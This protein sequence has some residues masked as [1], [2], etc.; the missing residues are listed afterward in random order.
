MKT[1]LPQFTRYLLFGA[2]A[3]I[4]NVGLTALLHEVIHLSEETAFAISL[5]V[6]F[7]INFILARYMIFQD[8]AQ[9]GNIVKQI[10][11]YIFSALTFRTSEYLAFLLIHTLLGIRYI[12]SL[13]VILGISFVAKFF[14]YRAV[15]FVGD[16]GCMSKGHLRT[17]LQCAKKGI[18]SQ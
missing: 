13:I 18:A 4:A 9:S 17:E 6:M 2:L 15:V 3:F 12:I 11:K 14:Y 7:N 1:T 5:I 16:R 8:E 10:A